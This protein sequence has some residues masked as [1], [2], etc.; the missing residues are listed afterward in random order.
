MGGQAMRYCI[1]GRF[2]VSFSP[3]RLEHL[4]K[5]AVWILVYLPKTQL[6]IAP[7]AGYPC[8]A[9]QI[10]PQR[11]A[12]PVID[13]VFPLGNIFDVVPNVHLRVVE[14]VFQRAQ[15][16]VDIGVVQ[17]AN[18]N[19]KQ[20]NKDKVLNTKADHRQWQVFDAAVHDVFA[21][22]VTQVSSIAHFAHRVVHFMHLPQKGHPMQQ[23]VGI[24]LHKVPHEEQDEQLYPVRQLR[25]V[26]GDQILDTEYMGQQ[27]VESLRNNIRHCRI[28]HQP[29]Q[30]KIEEHIKGVQPKI[31]PDGRLVF[32]PG[33]QQLQGVHQRGKSDEPV[34]IIAPVWVEYL[35]PEVG[36]IACE[37]VGEGLP[38]I[39]TC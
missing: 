20:M 31:F 28:S 2:K 32:A 9:K 12:N 4:T 19:G 6:N 37:T 29:E 36:C 7:I 30:E 27:V 18:Q 3:K 21:K 22:V 26:D 33:E 34:E 10:I 23:S 1:S 24:P 17:V 11:Q 14:D 8:C 25:H 38:V 39:H 5:K 15:W 16:Q 13:A 35:A